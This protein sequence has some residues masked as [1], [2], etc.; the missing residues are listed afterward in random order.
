[1]KI[2]S[3]TPPAAASTVVS[4]HPA[5]LRARDYLLERQA[6]DGSWL[7]ESHIKVKVQKYFENGDPYGEHQFLSTA[8]TAWATAGLAQLLPAK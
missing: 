8:A 3:P 1:L 4:N 7:A 5:I 2:E 6:L